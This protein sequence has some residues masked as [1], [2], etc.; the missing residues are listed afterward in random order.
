MINKSDLE[1]FV[2]KE[3][4]ASELELNK[5]RANSNPI[6]IKETCGIKKIG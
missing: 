5:K 1:E 4:W 2:D 6:F 3:F